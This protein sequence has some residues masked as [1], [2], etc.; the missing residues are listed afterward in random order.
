MIQDTLLF[1][2]N[3]VEPRSFPSFSVPKIIGS[4]S[5]DENRAYISDTRNCKYVRKDNL[6]HPLRFNLNNG[7]ENVIRKSNQCENEKLDH[8]L[9]FITEHMLRLE[10]Q[11]GLLEETNQNV[12]RN[13]LN[14][15]F[16]CFRGLLRLIMCTPFENRDPWIILASKFMG[17]IYLCALETKQKKLER[18][19]TT[20]KTRR[21]FSYGYK[22]E[23]Y[24][25]TGKYK[26]Y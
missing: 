18:L 24:M 14:V 20:E 1:P 2:S 7:Y 9:K 3:I 22:F 21:I 8:L 4:F 25:L 19:N 6:E 13:K 15:E 12:Q 26:P 16:V 10:R 5:L 17:T 11:N 23:Q